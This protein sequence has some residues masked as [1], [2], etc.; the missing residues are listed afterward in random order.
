MIDPA[1]D[2]LTP[3]PEELAEQYCHAGIWGQENM[4]E[5]LEAR[6]S[7]RAHERVLSGL[8]FAGTPWQELTGAELLH[9]IDQMADG[10]A[11]LG[12]ACG[13]RVVLQL[14]NLTSEFSGI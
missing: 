4:A 12:L 3:W 11:R 9:Q 7:A 13:E 5:W 2:G 14:G 8:G 1:F 6:L 10:L